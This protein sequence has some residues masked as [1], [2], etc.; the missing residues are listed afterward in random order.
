MS[1]AERGFPD[2][3]RACFAPVINQTNVLLIDI[4]EIASA[5]TGPVCTWYAFSCFE[6]GKKFWKRNGRSFNGVFNLQDGSK[7]MAILKK[8]MEEKENE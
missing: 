7:S 5:E 4:V 6:E 2:D 8:Y 3:Q 1:F